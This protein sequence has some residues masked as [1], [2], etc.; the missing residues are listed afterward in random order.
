LLGVRSLFAAAALASTAAS[1]AADIH[2]PQDYPTIQ[3]AIDAA[4]SGARIVVARGTYYENLVIGKSITLVS[5]SGAAA[6][7]LDGGRIGPVIFARG[8]GSESVEISGFTIVNGLNLFTTSVAGPGAGG[9]IHVESLAAAAISDNVIRDNVGCLGVGISAL[10]VTVDI[11]HNQIL[12]NQQDSTCG[13]ADGGGIIVRGGGPEPSLIAA[14]LIAGHVIG[15]Y[16]AGIKIQGAGTVIRDNVIRDNVANAGGA[17]AFAV[18]S[19][20]VSDNLLIGNSAEVG[21][22]MWLT[23]TDDGNHLVV[24]GNMLVDNRASLGGSAIDVVVTDDGL[25]MRSNAIDGNTA[26]ELI[27]CETPFS[28]SRSNILR[29]ESGPTIGGDCTFGVVF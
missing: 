15:G 1:W 12:N 11:E 24:T 3:G 28:V 25:R 29:N 26:V 20:V 13:G 16:G 22:G 10:D 8:T 23:P 6:T 9:G 18:S 7:I 27:R 17:I 5:R 14:N 4:P 21:G 2:V 19:G